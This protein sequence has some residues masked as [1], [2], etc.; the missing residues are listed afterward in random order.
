[1]EREGVIQEECWGGKQA[2]LLTI[3]LTSL[4]NHLFSDK[5]DR[6]TLVI[7]TTTPPLGMPGMRRRGLS[8]GCHVQLCNFEV[9]G[10]ERGQ[11]PPVTV[12]HWYY[13]VIINHLAQGG[14][15]RR[16]RRGRLPLLQVLSRSPL[17]HQEPE[18]GRGRVS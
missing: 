8:E 10:W 14:A 6:E 1:M 2:W 11:T 4:P 13:D 9:R 5:A 18:E 16:R 7:K 17:C 3:M 12:T 15:R